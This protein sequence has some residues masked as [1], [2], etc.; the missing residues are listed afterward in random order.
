MA[1]TNAQRQARWRDKRNE[2]AN[3]L[4]GTPEQ[5]ANSILLRLG[6]KEA[7]RV[8]RALDEQL[9]N[10][11]PDCP[12]C[13]GK[14]FYLHTAMLPNGKPKWP[15]YPPF[16]LTCDCQPDPPPDPNQKWR[17]IFWKDTDWEYCTMMPARATKAEA[18]ADSEKWQAHHASLKR[19]PKGTHRVVPD[20]TTVAKC[21][22]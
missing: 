21:K 14:G 5:I 10:I 15:G 8:L 4:A 7:D 9:R 19:K 12:R 16:T 20:D 17:A 18:E 11:K 2:D 6:K 3:A 13:E 22:L 1:L